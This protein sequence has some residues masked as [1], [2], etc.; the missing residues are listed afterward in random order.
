[1]E[2]IIALYA[3]SNSGKTRTLQKVISHF[4]LNEKIESDQRIV[5]EIRKVKIAITTFGDNADEIEQNFKFAHQNHCE[6]LLTA[7]R[8]KGGSVNMLY[9]IVEDNSLQIDWIKKAVLSDKLKNENF[10]TLHSLESRCLVDYLYQA[11]DL[12]N[13]EKAQ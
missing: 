2:K 7:S 10:E 3:P 6:I 5:L 8:T 12:L 4:K 11:V 13:M 9:K 1:M